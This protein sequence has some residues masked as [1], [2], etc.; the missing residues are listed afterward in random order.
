[1]KKPFTTRIDED[2]LN[3]V[4]ALASITDRNINDLLEEALALLLDKFG[5]EDLIQQFMDIKV[6]AAKKAP[7]RK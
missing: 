2:L 7:S 1:M 4:N 5:R 6:K 3:K